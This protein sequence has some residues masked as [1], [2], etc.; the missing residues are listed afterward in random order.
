MGQLMRAIQEGTEPEISGRD[1]LR[2]LALVDACYQ[3]VAEHRAVRA[4]EVWQTSSRI[5]G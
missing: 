1:N 4:T 2:T 3:S 5:E